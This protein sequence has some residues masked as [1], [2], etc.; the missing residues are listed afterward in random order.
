MNCTEIESRPDCEIVYVHAAIV[1]VLAKFLIPSVPWVWILGHRPNPSV[2][3]WDTKVALNT[4]GDDFTGSVRDL[5][6]DLQLPTP[7]F[8]DRAA[9]FDNFGLVLIQSN[10]RMPDSLTLHGIPESQQNGILMQNGAVLRIF[11]PHSIETAQIQ[12]F[13]KGHL[14]TIIDNQD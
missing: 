11:L 8:V 10:Q 12:S 4:K 1:S 14:A 9:E 6:F 13:V 2:R 5:C 7:E 3:W